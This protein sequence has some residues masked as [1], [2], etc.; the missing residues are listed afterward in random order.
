VGRLP[1]TLAA[2]PSVIVRNISLGGLLIEAPWSLRTDSLHDICL[3]LGTQLAR[4]RARVCHVR[5]AYTGENFLI[6]LEF[7]GVDRHTIADI[8]RLIG[9]SSDVQIDG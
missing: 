6:G 9:P 7:I 1:G 8:D 5:Q 3:D 2:E 4:L